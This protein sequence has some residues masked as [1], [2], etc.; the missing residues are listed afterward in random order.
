[1]GTDNDVNDAFKTVVRG[2]APRDP[3]QKK[4]KEW[5]RDENYIKYESHDKYGEAGY[6]LD[7]GFSA[8]VTVSSGFKG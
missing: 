5:K 3:C 6:A 7:T 2:A 4:K 1:M 8:Q